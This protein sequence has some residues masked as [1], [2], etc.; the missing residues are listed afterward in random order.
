MSVGKKPGE[1]LRQ[2]AAK[3]SPFFPSCPSGD[4]LRV[5]VAAGERNDVR[6]ADTR[7][8]GHLPDR[9]F[10]ISKE[11]DALVARHARRRGHGEL[12]YR[13]G[14]E[15]RRHDAELHEAST[16]Q[17]RADEQ[18]H[19]QRHFGDDETRRVYDARRRTPSANPDAARAAG[20]SSS[21]RS[22]GATPKVSAAKSRDDK[23]EEQERPDRS[24][25]SS[26]RGMFPGLALR[27]S[28]T[29]GDREQE[30][31]ERSNRGEHAA[32]R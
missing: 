5:R 28:G 9:R 10:E 15:A 21:R 12:Q 25:A 23:R 6:R 27:N 13:V 30:P 19:R 20:S 16:K 14:A 8:A 18:H 31:A 3:N 32:L 4:E 2:F 24:R 11:R 1:T 26:S 29:T 7:H 22:P 17:T